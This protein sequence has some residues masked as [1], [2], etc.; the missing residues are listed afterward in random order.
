MN[1]DHLIPMHCAGE[2]FIRNAMQELPVKVLRT[3]TGMRLLY[4]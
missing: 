2:A 4:V 1:S 3:S